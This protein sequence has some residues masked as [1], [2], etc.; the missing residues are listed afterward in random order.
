MRLRDAV[1]FSFCALRQTQVAGCTF[2]HGSQIGRIV[3]GAK[4]G[5]QLRPR[6][7]DVTSALEIVPETVTLSTTDV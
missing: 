6:T 1:L 3:T 7:L 4:R 2:E 5:T